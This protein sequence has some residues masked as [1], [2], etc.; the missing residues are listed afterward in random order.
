MSSTQDLHEALELFEGAVLRHLQV[1]ID[2]C[3]AE[4]RWCAHREDYGETAFKTC[5]AAAACVRQGQSSQQ[6]QQSLEKAASY[7][8]DLALVRKAAGQL[9]PALTASRCCLELAAQAESPLYVLRSVVLYDDFHCDVVQQEIRR[10]LP[11]EEVSF[12]DVEQFIGI[13]STERDAGRSLSTTSR[14]NNPS[15]IPL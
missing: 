14:I 13:G 1:L 15:G 5:E 9:W 2:P 6:L 10:P 7:Y 8:F 3:L 11:H 4:S 12:D